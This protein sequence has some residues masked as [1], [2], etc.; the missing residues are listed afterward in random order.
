MYMR[1]FKADKI[2]LLLFL[3]MGVYSCASIGQPDGGEYDETPPK[4]IKSIPTPFGVNFNGNKITIEFD[5]NVKLEKASE[6]VIV[7]PPQLE[8]PE[9]KANGRNVI[10]EL[11]DSIKQ[12]T[13]YTIDFSDAIVDNNEGNPLGNFA[14]TFSTGSVVDTME[15]SGTVLNAKNL[16]PIKGILVGLHSDLSDSAFMKKPFERVGRTDSRGHFTIRGVAPNKYKIYALLDGNQN[17]FYDSKS[18]MIAFSD[19]IIVPSS[20]P[21]ERQDTVWRDSTHI[22]TIKNVKYTRFLP[23][24]IILKAFRADNDRQFLTKSQRDNINHFILQFSA[25]A[26]TLPT[27]KGLNFDEKDAFIIEKTNRNDSICYWIKDSLIYEKDTLEMKM[28]YLFSDSLGNLVPKTDTL[29]LVNKYNKAQ[30]DKFEQQ[31]RE[32]KDKERKKK[33]KKG[34]VYIEP[35]SFLKMNPTISQSMDI[36]KNIELSFEEPIGKIDTTA[37]HLKIKKDTLWMDEPFLIMEDSIIPRKY[38]ILA[39][40]IPEQ[41]YEFSMDSLAIKGIYGLYT[42]KYSQKFKIKKLEDY[43]T[44]YLNIVG[45]DS[46]AIA[47]LLDSKEQVLDRVK[48]GKN[49]AADFYFLKPETKYYVRMF[50]DSNNNGIWDAGNFEKNIQAEEMFYFPKSWQMKANFE[51]NETWDIKSTPFDR[52]KLNEI[53]KQKPEEEKKIKD[54]NLERARKLGR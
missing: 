53:K 24:N 50:N 14:L 37:I 47:E 13:T 41:E 38:N 39:E 2:L 5:E 10:V 16:E 30:R 28:D 19:S 36:G 45:A 17:S 46:N 27:L 40:W 42:D 31:A 9:I 34:E 29:F 4:F 51:F 12:N 33:E 48:V 26:D 8:M 21:S 49:G 25:K 7:S 44:L 32:Q 54:R 6:K 23:D 3:I 20:M 15:V 43:G 1:Y 52:Q 11:Q 35:T 18:E 22:D